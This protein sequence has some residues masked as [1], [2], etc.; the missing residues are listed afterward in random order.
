MLAGSMGSTSNRSVVAH[1]RQI[2]WGRCSCCATTDN[3]L[4]YSDRTVRMWRYRLWMLSTGPIIDTIYKSARGPTCLHVNPS[5]PWFMSYIGLS[6]RP[7]SSRVGLKPLRGFVSAAWETICHSTQFLRHLCAWAAYRHTEG[8]TTSNQSMW[9]I[10]G[11][12]EEQSHGGK[13]IRPSGST[14]ISPR[15]SNILDKIRRPENCGNYV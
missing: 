15:F 5:P 4:C 2:E 13:S 7:L 10:N 6:I 9:R 11:L 3:T 14:C 1:M 8:Q 12:T